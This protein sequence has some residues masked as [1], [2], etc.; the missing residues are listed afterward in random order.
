M[1]F[2]SVIAGVPHFVV[3]VP[4][5][6]SVNVELVGSLLRS[7]P[8]LGPGG[9]NIDFLGPAARGS[10]LIRTFERGVE[11][12]TLACGSGALAAGALLALQGLSSPIVLTPTSGIDLTVEFEGPP[13]APHSFR[14]SGEARIVF[15]GSLRTATEDPAPPADSAGGDGAS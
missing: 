5:P 10:R 7:H 6:E 13:A 12:E 14:L 11:G 8:A 15:E 1:L 9:A 4:S 2:R 3:P